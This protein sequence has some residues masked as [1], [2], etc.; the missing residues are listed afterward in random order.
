MITA[1][2]YERMLQYVDVVNGTVINGAGKISRFVD[3][4]IKNRTLYKENVA[5]AIPAFEDVLIVIEKNV[6]IVNVESRLVQMATI[7]TNQT[8][9]TTI[10]NYLLLRRLKNEWKVQEWM[11]IQLPNE[12]KSERKE[13][14]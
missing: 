9:S 12:P 2:S 4:A 3:D 7:G 6:A 8:E 10:R 5:M 14:R 13:W 11:Q 1:K